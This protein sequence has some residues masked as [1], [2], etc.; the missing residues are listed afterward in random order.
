[1]VHGGIALRPG[2]R[3]AEPAELTFLHAHPACG[4]LAALVAELQN[5][6]R[7]LVFAARPVFF[8]DLPFDRQ[9][10]AVPARDIQSIKARFLRRAVHHILENFVQRGADVQVTIGIGRAI[11]EYEF[12]PPEAGCT[13]FAPNILCIPARQ[14]RRLPLRQIAAHGE[15]CGG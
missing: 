12:L 14:D 11:V 8:L 15:G 6:H 4:V 3:D 1:M 7:V 9:A 5:R 10:V 2:T 13:Q